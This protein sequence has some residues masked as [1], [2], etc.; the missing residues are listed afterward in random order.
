MNM[1]QPMRSLEELRREIDEI[2]DGI[3]DLI[4][5]RAALLSE[6]VAAKGADKA[7]AGAFLRPGREAVVLRRLVARHRGPFPKPALVRLW[8]EIIAAPL[9]VQGS[10]SVAVYAP[11]EQPGY[12]DLARDHYG[13]NTTFAAHNTGSQVI[14]ALGE[15]GA[16]VG[17][18]PAI[19]DDDP[20]PWWRLLAR[21]GNYIPH[22]MARLPMAAS[23][24]ARGDGLAA[25]A[26]GPVAPEPT[27][28][29]HSYIVLEAAEELSRA[30]L[31]TQLDKAGLEP[32][33]FAMWDETGAP[34]RLILVE[35]REFVAEGDARLTR[36]ADAMG[37]RIRRIFCLGGYALP[38]EAKELA[39][40]ADASL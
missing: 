23:G 28:R 12:W 31:R 32:C 35:V 37:T 10:F 20:D 26:V 13:S 7:T 9:A 1:Q 14:R 11:K 3:H 22:V 17:V 36:F 4:M 34:R 2:D 38:F 27:G 30:A 24:N 16:V 19:Q 6:V 5:R 40:A 18:L 25:L 39:A 15:G 29:D 33:F 21:E 8:R